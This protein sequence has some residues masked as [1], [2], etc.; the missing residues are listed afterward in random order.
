MNVGNK[1][2]TVRDFSQ[3]SLKC[4]FFTSDAGENAMLVD[5]PNGK[6]WKSQPASTLPQ[7]HEHRPQ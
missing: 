2:D 7:V 3:A 1:M 5:N 4:D 6:Q